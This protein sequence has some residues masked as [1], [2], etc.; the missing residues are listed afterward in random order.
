[1]VTTPTGQVIHFGA[2]GYEDY[3]M[4]G[5]VMRARD[6]LRRHAAREDWNDVTTPGYWARWLLW[7]KPSLRAAVAALRQ[8]LA[9]AK[10]ILRATS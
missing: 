5:D 9:P 7:E 1:M 2:A 10:V 8:R 4:H 3:T 6:Y